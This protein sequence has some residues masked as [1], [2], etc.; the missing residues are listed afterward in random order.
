V[1]QSPLPPRTTPLRR[2]GPLRSVTPLKATTPLERRTRLRPRSAKTAAVYQ[3]RRPLVAAL[4]AGRPWCEIRWDTA[5]QRRSVD[6]HEP[7]MRSRGADICDPG[8]CVTCCRHCHN[9]VHANPAEAT[10]RGWLIPSGK[11]RAA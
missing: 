6:V 8:Q 4:L 5:C 9:A 2:G 7:G 1:K 11:R 3:T 10:R